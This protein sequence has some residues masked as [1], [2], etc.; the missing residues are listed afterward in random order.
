MNDILNYLI[1]TK[2]L[3]IKEQGPYFIWSS[4]IESPIYC[5]NRRLLSYPSIRKH[6]VDEFVLMLRATNV[7]GICAVATAGIPWASMISDRLNLPLIYVRSDYKKHGRKNKIEGNSSEVSCVAVIEDLISTGESSLKVVDAL[8]DESI[9][10]EG[11]YSLFNYNL[12]TSKSRFK[13]YNVKSR[14]LGSINEIL[15]TDL[16]SDKMKSNL[17]EFLC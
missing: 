1:E 2:S 3:E 8:V 12:E 4:G 11:V 17:K 13:E 14:S 5:D 15:E 9:K 10:V 7:D 16:L 6:I